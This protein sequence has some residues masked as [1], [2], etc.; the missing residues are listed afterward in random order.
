MSVIS[1]KNISALTVCLLL[2]M[3]STLAT[4]QVAWEKDFDSALKKAAREEK[5]VILDLSASW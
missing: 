5:F 2:A 4:A 1:R 3:P